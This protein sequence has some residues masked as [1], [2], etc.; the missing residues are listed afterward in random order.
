M[1]DL[2]DFSNSILGS[3]ITQK[4]QE[5]EILLLKFAVLFENT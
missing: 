3:R 5:I 4:Y 2:D 1:K